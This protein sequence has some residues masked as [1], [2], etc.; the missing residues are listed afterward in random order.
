[1]NNEQKLIQENHYLKSELWH[2]YYRVLNCVPLTS[3][4]YNSICDKFKKLDKER[5]QIIEE[6]MSK[7]EEGN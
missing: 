1:M 6:R 2:I 7:N 4:Y 5:N 3:E